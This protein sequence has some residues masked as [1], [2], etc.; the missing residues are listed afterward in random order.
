MYI[1]R[2][3]FEKEFMKNRFKNYFVQMLIPSFMFGSVTGIATAVIICLYKLA[4]GYVIDL[5]GE[6]YGILRTSPIWL[7]PAVPILFALAAAFAFIYRWEPNLGGGGIPTAIGVLRGI[8]PMK[9]IKNLVGV[10]MM[11]LTTFFIGVPLGNEGPSVQMGTAVGKCCVRTLVKKRHWA[12]ERYSMTGGAC[13]GFAV[14]TGAPVSGILFSIEEAHQRI[15][16][17]IITVSA[18]SVMFAELTTRILTR[19]LPIHTELFPKLSLLALSARDIWLPVVVGALVGLFAVLFLKYY[20]IIRKFT[21]FLKR[22]LGKMSDVIVIFAVFVI[23]AA[24]GLASDS[25]ISTGHHLMLELFEDNPAILVI[26]GILLVRST[27]TLFANTTGITGGLFVPILALGALFSALLSGLL[28]DVC[29]IEE[30]YAT[31]ILVLGITACISAMMKM[32]LTSIVFA[33]EAL[34]SFEN[35]LFIIVVAVV[36]YIIT[37]FFGVHSITDV[38][39]EHRAESIHH[40]MRANVV[41]AFVT[42]NN[43]SFAVGKQVRD[44]LWPNNL[45][46]LSIKFSSSDHVEIDGHGGMA[47]RAGDVL[48]VRYQTYDPEKTAEELCAIVGEQEILATEVSE[49]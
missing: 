46:V 5:S 25:F 6:V 2:K 23:T 31:V 24:L 43:G 42:V 7:V 1:I 20:R 12:W 41:E 13:A 14:A 11:S 22:S 4:A 32:P 39:L 47:I 29:G 21:G 16:P 15:S 36:S 30:K 26:I 9:F 18:T 34:S 49:K 28:V 40:G 10:F 8:L 35:T 17:M 44:I 48:H 33:I 3:D 27:L 38:V 19:F 37:E 45:F